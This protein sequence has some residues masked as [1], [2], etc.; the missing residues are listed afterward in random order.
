MTAGS[1]E[2]GPGT[3]LSTMPAWPPWTF[4]MK[5]SAV[6]SSRKIYPKRCNGYGFCL[7]HEKYIQKSE[8]N[9]IY[10]IMIIKCPSS[11]TRP[12][13]GRVLCALRARDEL[14]ALVIANKTHKVLEGHS[15]YIVIAD[16]L[17]VDDNVILG[18]IIRN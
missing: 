3:S 18:G 13:G 1:A 11:G 4:V 12:E 7:D 17:H 16:R 14:G 6:T 10:K 8:G 9:C 2:D 15:H 5:C